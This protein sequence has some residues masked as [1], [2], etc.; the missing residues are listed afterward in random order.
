MAS[1]DGS[2]NVSWLK[3]A[4]PNRE[5]SPRVE[6]PLKHQYTSLSPYL[7]QPILL[8]QEQVGQCTPIFATDQ[9]IL[10]ISYT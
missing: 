3:Q 1:Q 4:T 2:C 8:G 10:Y 9:G 5:L 6:L 7:P